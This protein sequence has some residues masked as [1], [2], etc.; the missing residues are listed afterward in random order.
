MSMNSHSKTAQI[1]LSEEST[2][3][4][5]LTGKLIIIFEICE[6]NTFYIC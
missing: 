3:V 5:S 4:K 1:N 6:I 2:E